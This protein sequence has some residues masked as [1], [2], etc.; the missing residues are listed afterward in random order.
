MMDLVSEMNSLLFFRF[1][2]KKKSVCNVIGCHG[3][4]VKDGRS[5]F[6]DNSNGDGGGETFPPFE[7]IERLGNVLLV[8]WCLFLFSGIGGGRR[9]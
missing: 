9:R 7:D 1:L 5:F 3:E 2:T 6:F 4:V 8:S